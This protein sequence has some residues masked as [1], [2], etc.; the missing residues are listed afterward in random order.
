M[1]RVETNKT[2]S[3]TGFV[4]VTTTIGRM[5][6][7]TPPSSKPGPFIPWDQLRN[8]V[9]SHED[10][11]VKDAT[12]IQK[13]GV[14]YIFF[15]AFFEDV[16]QERSHVSAVK[17]QDFKTFSEPLFIWDGKKDGWIGMCSP[18]IVKSG[19]I[20]YLTYN[21]WG[22]KPGKV[23]QLLY[24]VSKDLETWDEIHRPLAA[25]LTEGKRAIDA[26][27]EFHGGK[28]YLVWKEV[29]TPQI[30]VA[31]KIGADGWMRL[32][33]TNMGWFENGQFIRVDGK[34]LLVCVEKHRSEKTTPI[35]EIVDNGDAD[36]HW[37]KWKV[38]TRI[39]VPDEG[40]NSVWRVNSGFLVDWRALDG[41]FY[42]LYSGAIDDKSHAKRGNMKLA[43][44]R[45]K[46]LV[47]WEVP[48]RQT[49]ER[50]CTR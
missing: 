4:D 45:S 16:G 7:V 40:F 3:A 35:F 10:W 1:T 8:P 17:T 28:C 34:W 12:M 38:K 42:H 49:G 13:D 25:N 48:G 2:L 43:L 21:T 6:Q 50:R 23:N 24:A 15:S 37:V 18:N 5:G 22:D 9:Y 44:Q 39:P 14:F 19:N 30:A 32:G 31:A 46:D 20:Y 27:V 33:E 29:Q 41:Y 36:E 26:A 47:T 11:C